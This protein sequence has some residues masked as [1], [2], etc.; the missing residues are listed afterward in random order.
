MKICVIGPSYPFKGGIAHY[1]TLLYKELKKYHDV[2]FL[3]F[4]RQYPAWLYPGGSDKDESNKALGDDSVIQ[5]LDSLNPITWIK[6][7]FEVKKYSPDLVI[8]P[9]WVAFW[10]PQFGMISWL[11]KKFTESRVLFICHNVNEHEDNKISRMLTKYVLKK[12][13]YFVVHSDDDLN[14]LRN[15]IKNPRVV[16]SFH[17]TYEVFGEEN[18]E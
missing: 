11:I 17:P 6:V 15:M 7:F 18:N 2:K 14:N 5:M 10:A 8:F 3:S 1:T 16:K 13:D 4:K 9:W 12:G